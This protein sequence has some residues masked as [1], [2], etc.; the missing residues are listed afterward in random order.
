MRKD[1]QV[2]FS[3]VWNK[4]EIY[5]LYAEAVVR[6]IVFKL[7]KKGIIYGFWILQFENVLNITQNRHRQAFICSLYLKGVLSLTGK[8]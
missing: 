8:K 6:A 1:V 7:S 5:T 2:T 3:Y 4:A